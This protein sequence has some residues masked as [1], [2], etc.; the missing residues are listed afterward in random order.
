MKITKKLSRNM[1]NK[2]KLQKN[3]MNKLN[4]CRK[5]DKIEKKN[6]KKKKI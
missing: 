6:Y 5:K 4:I 1:K 2:I 3:Q